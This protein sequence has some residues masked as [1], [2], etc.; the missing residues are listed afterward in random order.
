[1]NRTSFLYPLPVLLAGIFSEYSGLDLFL[2]RRF[3]DASLNI[4]TYKSCW[5]TSDVL[6]TGGKDFVAA[7]I[8]MILVVFIL[9][10]FIKGMISYSKEGLSF[11]NILS[12]AGSVISKANP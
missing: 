3:Y 12:T 2:E 1:M 8:G 7:I 10:F 9:S 11:F 6:H 4:W 5:L